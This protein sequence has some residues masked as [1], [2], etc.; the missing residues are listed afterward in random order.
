MCRLAIVAGAEAVE[1]CG[2]TR[3]PKVHAAVAQAGSQVKS[4]KTD[5]LG[6]LLQVEMSKKWM[7]LWRQARFQFKMLPTP[8]VRSSF[9]IESLQKDSKVH[10]T[11]SRSTFRSQMLKRNTVSDHFWKLRCRQSARR[12]GLGPELEVQMTKNARLCRVKHIHKSKRHATTI[13]TTTKPTLSTLERQ[14]DRERERQR[15]R[16]RLRA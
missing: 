6:P 7:L 1:P 8:W 5:G 2:H 12:C 4:L 13:T 3:D 10:V 16:E 11:L 9:G 15:E 14:R